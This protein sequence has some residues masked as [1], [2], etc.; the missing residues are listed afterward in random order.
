MAKLFGY[1][2]HFCKRQLDEWWEVEVTRQSG[3][4]GY[5][6]CHD[7]CEE[8]LESLPDRVIKGTGGRISAGEFPPW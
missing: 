7:C 8:L 4:V 2:C 3:M 1:Y 5:L 6:V